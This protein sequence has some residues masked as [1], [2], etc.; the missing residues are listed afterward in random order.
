ME[1]LVYEKDAIRR[2]TGDAIR[3]GGLG[4]TRRA[5][6]L[7][8]LRAGA[9]VLDVGC[10]AG[11]TLEYLLDTH[12]VTP[13]GVDPSA[14]LLGEAR[15]G[16]PSLRLARARGE[17][18]PFADGRLDALVAECSL[19]LMDN[20]VDALR[21]FARVLR[22]GGRLILSD[23]YARSPTGIPLL[24][25]LPVG[26]CLKGAMSREELGRMLGACGFFVE[27]WEDHTEDLKHLAARLVFAHGSMESF[28]CSVIPGYGSTEYPEIRRAVSE[29]R[30]GYFLLLAKRI[31]V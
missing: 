25:R 29:S 21:E 11:A 2:V 7:C 17:R 5:M 24:R 28:W 15:R 16:N 22:V 6:E 8:P 12:R 14:R 10:G 19:S 26:C 13:F 3:P 27:V 18:L 31:T 9:R 23:M 1:C 30:P 20:V 4:L